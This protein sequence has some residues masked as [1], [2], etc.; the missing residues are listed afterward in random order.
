MADWLESFILT[1]I[2]LFIVID[3]IGSLPFFLT[4]SEGSSILERRKIIHISTITA[5][6]VGFAFLFFGRFI[7]H[8]LGISVGAFAIA[9]GLIL[10]ILSIKY[11][12]TGKFVEVVKDEMVAIV[13][14]GTPLL[15]GPATVTTLLL[16]EGQYP[17]YMV[18]ISFTINL[19]IV[20]VTFQIGNMIVRF[21]GQGGLKAVS[22]VFNLLLAA[23]AV[24]MIIRGLDLEGI[25]TV[26]S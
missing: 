20:W 7:L 23:I 9:G 22:N 12:L 11:L 3:A 26:S 6:I 5:F 19:I 21:L 2:P 18:L 8:V 1:F 17:L 4:I 16:L 14:I 25:I 10:L 13:P 24:A 15:A